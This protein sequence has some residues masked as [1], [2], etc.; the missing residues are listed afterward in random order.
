IRIALWKFVNADVPTKSSL[1][2]KCI[3]SNPICPRCHIDVENVNHVFRFCVFLRDVWVALEYTT[4]MHGTQMSF[5][6]WLSWMFDTYIKIK[7]IEINTTLWAFWFARNRLV[8]EG[9]NQ[10]VR[11]LVVFVRSYYQLTA[12]ASRAL[13]ASS[14]A[15]VRWYPPPR[16]FIKVNVDAGFQLGQK[17]TSSVVVIRDENGQS[18]EACSRITYPV[19]SMF[20][21]EA[22]ALTHGL[23]FAYELGFLSMILEGD[24]KSVIEKI[25]SDME[26]VT[27]CFSVVLEIVILK[28]LN[29]INFFITELKREKKPFLSMAVLASSNSRL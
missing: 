9:T 13:R 12:L 20:A 4:P 2:D 19:L 10:G 15:I 23:R 3:A 16:D 24:S 6:E 18:L 21:T 1:Y 27:T 28:S 17:K 25:R 29:P 11:E 8:H 22:I 14:N 26:N 7:H 5:H